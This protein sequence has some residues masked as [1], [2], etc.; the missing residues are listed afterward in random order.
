MNITVL[1]KRS[2]RTHLP[3]TPAAIIRI[4]DSLDLPALEGEYVRS[5][6]FSFSDVDEGPY[7]ITDKEAEQVARF[8]KEV[9][10]AGIRE[11]VVHCDYG[12]GRSPAVAMAATKY[13]GLPFDENAYPALNRLV[14]KKVSEKIEKIKS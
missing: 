12:A 2:A 13:F 14:L 3:E 6:R 1:D 5:S 9:P 10:E 4:S 7:A 8:I 11:L